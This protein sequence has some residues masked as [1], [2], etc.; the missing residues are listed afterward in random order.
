MDIVYLFKESPDQGSVELR[1]SL[2]SLKNFNHGKVFIV[3]EKP[4]W[5]INVEHVPVPQNGTK[6]QNVARN[7][8][9]A[10]ETQAISENFILMNDDFFF[11]KH[12]VFTPV[13]PTLHWGTMRSVIQ[14]YDERYSGESLYVNAMKGTLELLNSRGFEE[15][16]SY[17]LH[18]PMELNKTKVRLAQKMGTEHLS[19]FRTFY[20]NYFGIGGSYMDDVKVFINPKHNDPKSSANMAAYLQEQSFLSVTGISFLGG[21]AGVYIRQQFT[22]KSPYEV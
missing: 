13:L 6:A 16:L 3:G 19:Q 2:R 21:P 7:I 12:Q 15:P 9:A 8:F 20:G 1:Y 5:V 22:E 18:V 17:E 4:D 11:M 14:K 10:S